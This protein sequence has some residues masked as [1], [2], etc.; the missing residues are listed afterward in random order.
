MRTYMRKTGLL[1]LLALCSACN[2]ERCKYREGVDAITISANPSSISAVNGQSTITAIGTSQ[3]N[4]PMP[5]GTVI[6]FVTDLGAFGQ[7]AQASTV[8][9]I[10]RIAFFGTGVATGGTA[11][12]YARSGRTV[13]QS[14]PVAIGTDAVGSIRVTANPGSLPGSGGKVTVT[15]TVYSKDKIPLPGIG[16]RFRA[17]NGSLASQGNPRQSN[18]NGLA[19][20]KLTVLRNTT[21][22]VLEIT[23]TAEVGDVSGTAT[24]QQ[25]KP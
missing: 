7:G 2:D 8:D 22:D 25:Q 18:E 12:I 23:V 1:L 11:R 4:L 15:A 14:I 5:D 6:T 13:S 21:G 17:D 20:D 10:A 16:V 3:D 24:V 9:G 19:T